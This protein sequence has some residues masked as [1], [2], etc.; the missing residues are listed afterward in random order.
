MPI[1]TQGIVVHSAGDP[2]KIEEIT[3]S[4]LADDE[5]LVEMVAGGVCSRL[6]G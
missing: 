3:L 4:D 2:W 1:Q 6:N 5:I